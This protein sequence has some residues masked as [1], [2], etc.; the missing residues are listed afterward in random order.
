ML[1]VYCCLFVV[2]RYTLFINNAR[3]FF[4]FQ[5]ALFST[6]FS[7]RIL[8]ILKVGLSYRFINL[9]RKEI[10]FPYFLEMSDLRYFRAL[11]IY[12]KKHACIETKKELGFMDHNIGH[13]KTNNFIMQKNNFL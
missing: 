1:N 4:H 2:S 13:K 9:F 5:L 7:F 3:F 6:I 8:W 12:K 10:L 11:F